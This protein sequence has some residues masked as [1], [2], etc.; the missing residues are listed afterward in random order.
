MFRVLESIDAS[1]LAAI[2][3]ARAR[4]R[5]VAWAAGARPPR[6][7]N[8]LDFDATLITSHSEKEQAAANYKHGYGFHPLH[9][10]LDAT[11]DALAAL[12]RPG[13]AGSN[14]AADH[15]AVLDAA[16]A[17]LPVKTRV[18]DPERER[19][20]GV[21]DDRRS[22]SLSAP[23]ARMRPAGKQAESLPASCSQHLHTLFARRRPALRGQ[24]WGGVVHKPG[25]AA[26]AAHE[27]LTEDNVPRLPM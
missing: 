9:C 12:L 15:I 19:A 7:F 25:V 26:G 6:D 8:V 27:C 13:N 21:R 23:P 5:A 1:V 2:D 16:L 14:T 3:A 24:P 17:Q 18:A 20:R 11:N 22:W 4:A 10:F